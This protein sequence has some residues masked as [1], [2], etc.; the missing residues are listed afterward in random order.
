MNSDLAA[1][2]VR[3]FRTGDADYAIDPQRK[4]FLCP[5]KAG[6]LKLTTKGEQFLA[7]WAPDFKKAP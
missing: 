3:F 5:D 6:G 7:K 2:L 4:G 1:D